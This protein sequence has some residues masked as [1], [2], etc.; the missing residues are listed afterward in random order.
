MLKFREFTPKAPVVQHPLNTMVANHPGIHTLPQDPAVKHAATNIDLD[1]DSDVD[2]YD[3][4][5][6]GIPDE[7][8]VGSVKSTKKMFA[9]YKGEAGHT[10]KGMAYEQKKVKGFKDWKKDCGCSH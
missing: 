7:I 2:K 3:K 4:P 8:P 10:K 1:V 9:K 6:A 5:S